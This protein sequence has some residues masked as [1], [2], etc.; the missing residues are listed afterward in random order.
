MK[1]I[2]D[3]LLG[4][5]RPKKRIFSIVSDIL[6][7]SFS[8]WAAVSLRYGEL[9]VPAD[10]LI[11][12]CFVATVA[13]SIL[14]F[15]RL[16][17]YRAI[18]RYLSSQAYSVVFIGVGI[19]TLIFATSSFL[20]RVTMPRSSMLIYLGLAFLFV[21]GSRMLVRGYIQTTE[22]RQKEKIIIYGAGSAGLQ[23]L[24]ALHQTGEFHPIAYI[25]DDRNKQGTV[26]QGVQ[27]YSR[28]QLEGLC[29]RH[30]INILLLAIGN[31]SSSRRLKLL[32]YLEPL[33]VQVKTIPDMAELVSGRARIEQIRDIEIDDLLGRQ[34]VEAVEGL[35]DACIKEKVVMVSG[36]GGSIGSELCRHIVRLNPVRLV[37]FDQSEFGLYQIEGQL[38]TIIKEELLN[39]ELVAIMG[40]VQN[41][42][43]IDSVLRSFDVQTLYHAA[44]YKH[45]PMVEHNMI[46]GIRNNLF[47]T[48]RLAEAAIEAR[49]ETFVLISTDKAVRPTNVMG[50]SK[51][52]AELVLQGL[53]QTQSVTRFCMVRFGNVLGSSGS[54]VPLFRTQIRSGGPVT[55]T[56]EEITRYF[57]TIPEAVQLVLQAGSMGQ[58]GD[59]FILDMGESIRI[60][61]LAKRMIHLM[62]HTVRDNENPEGDIEITYTG[63]RPG[64]KLYEELLIGDNPLGTEHPQIM[65]AQE[66][67]LPW[68]EL[69]SLLDKI[70][71]ACL[72]YDCLQVRELLISAPTSYQPPAP[73]DDLVARQI[74][75]KRS[76][77]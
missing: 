48:V 30:N 25:D 68:Q 24:N 63:L 40:S 76:K 66:S 15:I 73:I 62:G 58:G 77:Q 74:D 7:L 9:F 70:D 60:A 69:K 17:L 28:E 65:R 51:R 44:A 11:Y 19:S 50:A 72:A 59:V 23:L 10:P 45:V 37:I 32:E 75:K 8:L 3:L 20:L 31:V 34:K 56:D 39:V 2:L 53:D 71:Q 13:T 21:G 61:D 49:V 14:V 16:G 54:V 41:Q 12:L 47:G 36:A 27:V 64:E 6:L 1:K 18:I 55:V 57:M 5:S 22:R 33:S 38:R 46:E 43:R 26:I 4:M 67:C 52:M 29:K 35:V 42:I